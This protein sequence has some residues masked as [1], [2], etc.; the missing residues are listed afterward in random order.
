MKRRKWQNTARMEKKF[1]YF[2]NVDTYRPDL[3]RTSYHGSLYC[4]LTK[5][6]LSMTFDFYYDLPINSARVSHKTPLRTRS[7]RLVVKMASFFFFNNFI[8][9]K[10][11]K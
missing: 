4:A 1:S 2:L 7:L 9:R 10:K 11:Y 3:Y 8:K 5:F 6:A